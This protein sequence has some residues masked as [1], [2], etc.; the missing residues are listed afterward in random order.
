MN[1][2]EGSPIICHPIFLND[3]RTRIG[4]ILRNP[5]KLDDVRWVE[6]QRESNSPFIRDVFSQWSEETIE[7]NTRREQRIAAVT[8]QSMHTQKVKEERN[9]K[10]RNLYDAKSKAVDAIEDKRLRR[11]ARKSTDLEEIQAIRAADILRK[12]G[13][14]N[15]DPVEG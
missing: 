4:A 3:A 13:E 9:F 8:R 2:R 14:E 1:Y 12:L 5:L 6:D 10:Q 11:M 15:D 7:E